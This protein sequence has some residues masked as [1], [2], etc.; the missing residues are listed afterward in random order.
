M[1]V[2]ET[3]KQKI[4]GILPQVAPDKDNPMVWDEY[5]TLLRRIEAPQEGDSDRLVELAKRLEIDSD[6]VE[7]HCL[8]FNELEKLTA[9]YA[10][11]PERKKAL[12]ENNQARRTLW[13]KYLAAQQKFAQ[14]EERLKLENRD[15]LTA[16]CDCSSM[17]GDI[18]RLQNLFPKLFNIDE[19]KIAGNYGTRSP[20]I[21]NKMNEIRLKE[22]AV[23]R[24]RPQPPRGRKGRRPQ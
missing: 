17:D 7:L 5:S 12:D 24:S 23:A 18:M 22:E 15:L 11:L 20:D 1:G 19:K 3:V 21:L 10:R 4:G 6:T 14:A 13:A 16:F 8:V 9:E 2:S